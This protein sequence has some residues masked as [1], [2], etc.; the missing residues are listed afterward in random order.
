MGRRLLS[1][2]DQQSANQV[3]EEEKK[4]RKK[5]KSG[6]TAPFSRDVN[7]STRKG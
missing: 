1:Q 3:F 5:D 2:P 6:Q 7:A 4:K